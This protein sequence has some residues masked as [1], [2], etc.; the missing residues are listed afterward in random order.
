M[1]ERV[2]RNRDKMENPI[3]QLSLIDRLIDDEPQKPHDL[4]V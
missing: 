3:S 1:S 2:T 4:A